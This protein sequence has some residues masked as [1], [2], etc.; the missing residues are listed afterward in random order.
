MDIEPLLV[1]AKAEEAVEI[2]SPL[3]A[4]STEDPFFASHSLKPKQKNVEQ[5]WAIGGGKG[6]V[7][8]SL[9]SSSLAISLARSGKRVIAIDLDIGAANLHTVFGLDLPRQTLGDFLSGRAPTLEECV[10]ETAIPNLK[11]ISGAQDSIKIVNLNTNMKQTLIQK[12]REL[13]CDIALLDLGAGTHFHTLD[14]F[15]AAEAGIIVALPEPTSIENAYRFIKSIYYR[16]LLLSDSLK[17]IH[18][19][20]EEAM[21][22]RSGSPIKSPSDLFKEV[23]KSNPETAMRLKEEINGFRP[24]LIINQVRTQSDIEIGFSMKSVC[25]K[26][27]GIELD[28]LGYLDYDSAVW[29]AIRR[30]KPIMSEFP[31]SRLVFSIDRMTSFL[32]KQAV[33]RAAEI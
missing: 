1:S 30:K 7:G 12:V 17:S 9:I 4:P 18:P 22:G 32:L 20:I 25:K 5:I 24:K 13:N 27:F 26:Y 23:S 15:N 3:V 33:D 19:W 10:N 31:N 14:F 16:R 21:D 28:Y 8:K 6:G 11:L 29:Q 2:N